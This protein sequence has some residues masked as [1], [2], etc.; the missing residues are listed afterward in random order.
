MNKLARSVTQWTQACDRRVAGLIS[1]IH[2]TRNGSQH[3]YVG[4][5][6]QSCRFGLFPDAAFAGDLEDSKPTLGEG[7]ASLKVVHL[8]PSVGVCKKRTLEPHSSIE[9]EVIPL[10]AGLRMNGFSRSRFM[11]RVIEVLNLLKNT[12]T[13]FYP[14]SANRHQTEE[15]SLKTWIQKYGS[16]MTT[17]RN[18]PQKSF[19]RD[20]WNHFL[21]FESDARSAEC[22]IVEKKATWHP[23]RE[24][25]RQRRSHSPD[26]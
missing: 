16:T 17:P 23:Q 19:T 6:A 12:Q 21:S 7:C 13:T 14:V 24:V 4:D 11:G 26:L 8:S 2:H 15:C 10:D 9:S 18:H 5:T 1:Y 20:E 25:V 3:C 22:F